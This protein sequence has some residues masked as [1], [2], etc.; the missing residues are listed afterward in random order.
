MR[1][2]RLIIVALLLA[3]C[4]SPPPPKQVPLK[5]EVTGTGGKLEGTIKPDN[6]MSAGMAQRNIDIAIPGSLELKAGTAEYTILLNGIPSTAQLKISVNGKE[7]KRGQDMVWE[8]DKGP[9]ITFTVNVLQDTP[10]P[11]P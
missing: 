6:A 3:G 10:T 8:D 2:F 9:R 7:L 11:T 1:V 4:S 5:L